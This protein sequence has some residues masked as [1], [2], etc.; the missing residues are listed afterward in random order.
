MMA[1]EVPLRVGS[2]SRGR[3]FA[4]FFPRIESGNLTMYKGPAPTKEHILFFKKWWSMKNSIHHR[5]QHSHSL[6]GAFPGKEN[7]LDGL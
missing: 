3:K 7:K 4:L 6:S 5:H 2:E 1:R